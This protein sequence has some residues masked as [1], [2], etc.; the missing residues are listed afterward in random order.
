MLMLRS[1]IGT[2]QVIIIHGEVDGATLFLC[3]Y[4]GMGEWGIEMTAYMFV[5][6]FGMF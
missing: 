2:F 5:T 6:P 4:P 1:V 3:C